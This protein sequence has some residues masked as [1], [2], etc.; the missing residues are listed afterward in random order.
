MIARQFLSLKFLLL[1]GIACAICIIFTVAAKRYNAA[2][3]TEKF[4]AGSFREP[5]GHLMTTIGVL[6]PLIIGAVAFLMDHGAV[7]S[8]ATLLSAVAILFVAFI[9]GSWLTFALVSRSTDDDKI[10]L[11]FPQDWGYRAASGVVYTG[12]ICGVLLVAGYFLFEFRPADKGEERSAVRILVERP[13][14]RVG[15]DLTS[16]RAQLGEAQST[17]NG[18]T[19]WV[20]RTDRST[21][22]I[23]FDG[24]GRVLRVTEEGGDGQNER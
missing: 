13:V 1:F 15:Q 22:R 21:L 24:A 19:Q 18:G 16:V 5:I 14:P 20:Y 10:E 9:V 23:D 12:L 11:K 6:L 7:A 8:M 4:S 17:S 2:T 3:K